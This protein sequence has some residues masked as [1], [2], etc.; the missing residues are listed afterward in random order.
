MTAL[1][2]ASTEPY[3][4]LLRAIY[5]AVDPAAA[6]TGDDADE[7][8]MRVATVRGVIESITEVGVSAEGAAA[9][10]RRL[11][12]EIDGKVRAGERP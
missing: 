2:T 11:I 1:R 8:R 5:E 9:T 4:E 7:I 3:T 12:A 6:P 10:L